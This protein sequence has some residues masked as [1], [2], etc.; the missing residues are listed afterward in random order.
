[1]IVVLFI[2]SVSKWCLF[3]QLIGAQ[4]LGIIGEKKN[5]ES[6]LV[7]LLFGATHFFDG[8][9]IG[10]Q[11]ERPRRDFSLLLWQGRWGG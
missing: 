8:G 9:S 7:F 3:S 1:M 6:H 2:K 10:L 5:L 11:G 4:R